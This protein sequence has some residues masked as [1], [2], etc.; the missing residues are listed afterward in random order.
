M[1]TTDLAIGPGGN[2]NLRITPTLSD[3]IRS[4]VKYQST[5]SVWQQYL[6]WRYTI[7]SGQVNALLTGTT[8]I[9]D[10]VVWTYQF[11]AYYNSKHYGI[12]NIESPFSQY[13]NFFNNPDSYFNLSPQIRVTLAYQV[14]SNYIRAL[15]NIILNAPRTPDTIFVYKASSKYPDLPSKGQVPPDVIVFQ[16][17]FNSTSYDPQFNFLPFLPRDANCCMFIIR[18]P[19][20]IPVLVIDPSLGAYPHEREILLPFGVSF[21]VVNIETQVLDYIPFDNQN[22][23]AVQQYPYVLGEVYRINPLSC[24]VINRKP[25]DLYFTNIIF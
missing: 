21:D 10:I 1:N 17:P 24:S 14:V 5:L 6:I 22:V 19:A 15:E 9:E 23:I 18:I 4:H 16:K 3:L 7:G 8:N 13:L 11:F 20:N 2:I 25:I 12:Q